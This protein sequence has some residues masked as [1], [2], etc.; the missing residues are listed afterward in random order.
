MSAMASQIISLTSFYSTVYSRCR[1]KT[2]S[3]LRVAGLCEENSPMAGEFPAQ[4]ASNMENVSTWWR[5]HGQN[6]PVSNRK[7]KQQSANRGYI[8]WMYCIYQY[9]F[10]T[11][12]LSR[13]ILFRRQWLRAIIAWWD[14]IYCFHTKSVIRRSCSGSIVRRHYME[15][16]SVLLDLCEGIH[17]SL[18]AEA[19]QRIST[20]AQFSD[21]I[22][23][24]TMDRISSDI[25]WI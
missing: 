21:G 2:L 11:K 8:V 15:T 22:T 5:H 20:I 6:R 24:F 14:P 19:V 10:N 3:T 16:L 12:L 1:S 4:R 25:I 7:G 9:V 13:C 17:P 18:V 23:S